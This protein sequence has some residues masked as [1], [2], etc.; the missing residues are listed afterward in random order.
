M[1]FAKILGKIQTVILLFL[2]YFFVIGPISIISIISRKDFLDKRSADKESYW[3]ERPA[4]DPGLE[5][6]KRQ[7]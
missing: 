7:F 6:C 2:I 4:D 3:N 1:K 5:S